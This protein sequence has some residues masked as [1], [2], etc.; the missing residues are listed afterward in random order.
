MIGVFQ[1]NN[2]Q[3]N[4]ALMRKKKYMVLIKQTDPNYR[5]KFTPDE[6]EMLKKLVLHYGEND[7]SQISNKMK[8]RSARQCRE[9]YRNYLA[10]HILNPPWS[11]EEEELLCQKYREYGPKWAMITKFFSQRSDV[12]IKNHWASMR[13]REIRAENK[14]NKFNM[15]NNMYF[16]NMMRMNYPYRVQCMQPMYMNGVQY[17]VYS[18]PSPSPNQVYMQQNYTQNCHVES[19][20]GVTGDSFANRHEAA[21]E[22]P[23]IQLAHD[24]AD[25]ESPCEYS[26]FYSDISD[27]YDCGSLA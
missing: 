9:R 13:N 3:R 24:A 20:G 1:V 11:K 15:V 4:E 7:W 18:S 21:K 6:D 19:P 27:F 17:P 8:H 5:L 25:N 22:S 14:R 12:N 16:Q 10:P 23:S 26:C 2:Q